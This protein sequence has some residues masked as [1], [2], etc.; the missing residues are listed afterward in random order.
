VIKRI[1]FA[2]KRPTLSVDEFASGWPIAV[3]GV[4]QAPVDVQPLRVA[5][6]TIL[7]G[8]TGSEPKHDGIS[9]EWFADTEA[10]ERYD[11]WLASQDGQAWTRQLDEVVQ[12]DASPV[13]VADELVLRGADWLA[14]RW[15]DGGVK[16]KHMAIAR[17]ARDLTQAQ[18]SERW[19]SRAGQIRK[20]G[21]T[22]LSAIPDEARGLAYVQNHPRPRPEGD[23]AYDALNE[24]YFDDV[25]R[26]K[27]R[28]DF[29]RENFLDQLEPDLVRDGSFVAA[30]EE[31]VLTS[32]SPEN[33]EVPWS[34]TQR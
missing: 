3:A 12:R 19:R 14:Q 22:E 4:A 33:A 1:S 18:F 2:T 30:R 23:W 5:V 32:E 8:L 29:F 28:I 26:L 20:A 16:L 9:L 15:L 21:K 27:K 31:L 17:R 13:M 7:G 6:C 24:V 25:E 10:L 11:S 34:T